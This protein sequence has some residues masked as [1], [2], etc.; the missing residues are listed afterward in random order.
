MIFYVAYTLDPGE[1]PSNSVSHKAAIYVHRF[2]VSQNMA[3]ITT[4]GRRKRI[5]TGNEVKIILFSTVLCVRLLANGNYSFCTLF[6]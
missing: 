5:I 4:H 1:M 2:C 6:V 3:D